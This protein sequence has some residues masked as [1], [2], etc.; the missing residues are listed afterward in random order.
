M[1]VCLYQCDGFHDSGNPCCCIQSISKKH[2]QKQRRIAVSKNT[3]V[4]CAHVHSGGT[5]P[6]KQKDAL[7][8][9]TRQKLKFVF[10]YCLGGLFTFLKTTA[11][12]IISAS[13]NVGLRAPL[14]LALKCIPKAKAFSCPSIS[15][16]TRHLRAIRL[17]MNNLPS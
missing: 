15:W 17:A 5:T 1:L 14:Y 12:R 11:G 7:A 16:M 4:Q 13:A 10:G 9:W 8:L 3:V 6:L 2:V